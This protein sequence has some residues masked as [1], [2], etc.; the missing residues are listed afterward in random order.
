MEHFC[1]Y[2]ENDYHKAFDKG[3]KEAI[4]ILERWKNMDVDGRLYMADFMK[5]VLSEVDEDLKGDNY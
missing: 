1:Q 5:R 3:L 4:S 2:T